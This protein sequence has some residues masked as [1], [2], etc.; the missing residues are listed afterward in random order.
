M[1]R[2]SK[3]VRNNLVYSEADYLFDKQLA[4]DYV[5]Q[6][7][8]QTILLFKVDRKKTVVDE[9]YGETASDGV[10]YKDPIELN[11]RYSIDKTKNK[12]YESSQNVGRYTLVGNLTFNIY[13]DTLIDNNVDILYGDYVGVQIKSDYMIYFEVFND[14]NQDFDNSH[15]LFGYKPLYRT[16]QCSPV[17]KNVFKGK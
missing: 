6:D 13:I 7:I 4:I 11:V 1:S 14:G 8:N 3:I 9:L 2:K 10:V 12:T 17:D 15:T 5:K 16:I